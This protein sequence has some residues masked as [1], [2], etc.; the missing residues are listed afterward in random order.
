MI[1]F[2]PATRINPLQTK[3]PD[4]E[5]W[6]LTPPC[7]RIVL[8]LPQA[9]LEKCA[10]SYTTERA[11]LPV[12]SG[13][14]HLVSKGNSW[15]AVYPHP[16]RWYGFPLHHLIQEYLKD[17][18]T[19][20]RTYSTHVCTHAQRT[21]MIQGNLST[22][23]TQRWSLYTWVSRKQMQPPRKLV[24]THSQIAAQNHL[25]H[26]WII[27]FHFVHINCKYEH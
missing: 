3:F 22:K 1:H 17:P 5:K 25:T 27:S 23:T 15:Y 20:I 8:S 21:A 7:L 4:L 14:G 16:L 13:M 24:N 10:Y 6:K 26:V 18:H 9:D 12:Y 2:R 11:P 19:D